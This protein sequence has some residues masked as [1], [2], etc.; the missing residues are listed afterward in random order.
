[1]WKKKKGWRERGGSK[2]TSTRAP[3]KY[4]RVTKEVGELKIYIHPNAKIITEIS[5]ISKFLGGGRSLLGAL[6]CW[7]QWKAGTYGWN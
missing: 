7:V 2:Q 4:E 1:M 6:G 5:K 3:T